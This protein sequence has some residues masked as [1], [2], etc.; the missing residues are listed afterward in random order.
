MNLDARLSMNSLDGTP[1][2]LRKVGKDALPHTALGPAPEAVVKRLHWAEDVLGTMA[3]TTAAL[4]CVDNARKHPSIIYSG[5]ATS[6]LWQE[7]LKLHRLLIRKPEEF[8]HPPY[9][10]A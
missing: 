8:S 9:L 1:S 7:Q 3:P 2:S 4:Q 6:I 10:F 5:H